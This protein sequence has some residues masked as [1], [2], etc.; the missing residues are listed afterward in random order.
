VT[1]KAFIYLLAA[2]ARLQQ[3]VRRAFFAVQA[4]S[5]FF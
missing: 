2:E 1:F 3:N 5:N 4:G